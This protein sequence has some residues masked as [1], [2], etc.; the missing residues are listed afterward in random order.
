M[1][2]MSRSMFMAL[3]I[4]VGIGGCGDNQPADTGADQADTQE[5]LLLNGEFN[6]AHKVSTPAFPQA[7]DPW[8]TDSLHAELR[9]DAG[10][11]GKPGYLRLTG[12]M[13]DAGF[14]M[15][16]LQQPIIE[17]RKYM[18]TVAMHFRPQDS[19]GLDHG[20]VRL[21]ASSAETGPGAADETI[22]TIPVR[23]ASWQRYTF[24]P[25]TAKAKLARFGI[26]VDNEIPARQGV[27]SRSVVDIDDVRMVEVR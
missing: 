19:P 20:N 12:K 15:Q 18:V 25:W 8:L 23:S 10:F 26:A 3:A 17:G 22:A 2:S 1:R 6:T 21:V 14:V 11:N 7:I 16:T 9:A 13:N 4:A 5:N 27:L 24:G